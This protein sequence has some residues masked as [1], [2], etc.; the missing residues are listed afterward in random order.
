MEIRLGLCNRSQLDRRRLHMQ[1]RPR[2]ETKTDAGG[3]PE[4]A[5]RLGWPW[6]GHRQGVWKTLQVRRGSQPPTGGLLA[7]SQ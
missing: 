1:V 4:L 5:W 3:L 6:S 2:L 7:R